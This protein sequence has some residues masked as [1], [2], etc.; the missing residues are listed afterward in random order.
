MLY[1]NPRDYFKI[2]GEED[3][4]WLEDVVISRCKVGKSIEKYKMKWNGAIIE[5]FEIFGIV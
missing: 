2:S 5:Q 3:I 1:I 4:V